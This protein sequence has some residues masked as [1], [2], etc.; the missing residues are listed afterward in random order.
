MLGAGSWERGGVVGHV[1]DSE[2]VAQDIVV[3]GLLGRCERADST[4]KGQNVIYRAHGDEKT[5]LVVRDK[6]S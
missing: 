1:P 5:I 3:A 2:G 4:V 6:R